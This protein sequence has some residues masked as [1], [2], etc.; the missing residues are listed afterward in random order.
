MKMNAEIN[1]I[2]CI[3]YY[4]ERIPR[5]QAPL[6]YPYF[7]HLRHDENDWT[8]PISIER[9]VLADFF[10][11]VFMKEPVEFGMDDYVEVKQFKFGNNYMNFVIDDTLFKRM[12]GV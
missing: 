8:C 4:D 3:L 10:G 12:L 7:Y 1:G 5:E 9:F 6:G 11:T 2:S